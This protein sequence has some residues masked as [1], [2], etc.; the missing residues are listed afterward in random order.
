[1]IFSS[2]LIIRLMKLAKAV[3][4]F[5][6]TV[7]LMM[8]LMLLSSLIPQRVISR[9]ILESAEYMAKNDQ[10]YCL[11]NSMKSTEVDHYADSLWLSIA[12]GLK[13]NFESVMWTSYYDDP[14]SLAHKDILIQVE[15]N[16]PVNHEYL[17]YWHGATGIIRLLHVFLNVKESYILF[18]VILTVLTIFLFCLLLR[19]HLWGEALAILLSFFMTS[20]WITPFCLEYIWCPIISLIASIVTV[21]LVLKE[22][23]DRIPIFFMLIGMVT[24]YLDFL[25]TETLTLLIPLLLMLRVIRYR[26]FKGNEYC[27]KSKTENSIDKSSFWISFKVI[28]AWFA[29]YIGA[30][31]MKWVLASMILH[32]NVMPFVNSH[33]SER[34]NGDVRGSISTYLYEAI[35]RNFRCLFFIEYGFPG[36]IITL[37]LLIVLIVAPV[38]RGSVKLKSNI[39]WSM[40]GLYALLGSVPFIRFLV[41]HNHAWNHYFFTYRALASSIV[42]ICFI[43]MELVEGAPIKPKGGMNE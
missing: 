25:T 5:L 31:I 24:I 30:W 29:G 16:I 36:Q 7:M 11:I 42:A 4:V 35:V 2:G 38:V 18:A 33:I 14:M 15:Q 17:R 13:P 22:K 9:H 10:F 3:T 12:Y 8:A 28:V 32:Q 41:L 1:M 19:F 40:I 27:L 43:W 34:I 39:K 20:M 26:N 23:Y 21:N 6:I 37:L